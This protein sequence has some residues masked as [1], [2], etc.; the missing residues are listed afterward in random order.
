MTHPVDRQA[1]AALERSIEIPSGKRTALLF[2]V[3]AH[4]RGDWELRVL[5]NGQTIKKQ[6]VD[7]TGERWKPIRID[8]SPFAGQK[9][10]IR[11]EN[12]ANNWAWEFGYW[13]GLE[14]MSTDLAAN[15]Q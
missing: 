2:S 4:E 1:G 15:S 14:I 6:L 12:C 7:H 13:S 11:L 8:L 10:L 3:A 5:I 9:A